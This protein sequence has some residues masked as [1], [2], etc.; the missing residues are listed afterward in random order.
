VSAGKENI[1][2]TTKGKTSAKRA[3]Q[4]LRGGGTCGGLGGVSQGTWLAEKKTN[5]YKGKRSATRGGKPRSE[6][7]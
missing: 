7:L 2:N 3:L 6:T 1:G 5:P 4:F